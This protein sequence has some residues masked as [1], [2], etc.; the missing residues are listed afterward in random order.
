MSL[1]DAFYENE[2][3][4]L[5]KMKD[6]HD[7]GVAWVGTVGEGYTGEYE[8][9][10]SGLEENAAKGLTKFTVSIDVTYL[11]AALR[12]NKGD[13]LILKSFL[14]GVSE[15]LS[16]N[17]I[18]DFECTPTLNTSDTVTTKIDLNFDFS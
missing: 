16:T 17:L 10:E 12:G 1:R 14:S 5:Q 4:L 7:A 9:I 15:A 8:A 6:A 13:N 3:G 11:P 18:Y 2:T